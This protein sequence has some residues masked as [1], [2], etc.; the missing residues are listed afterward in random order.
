MEEPWSIH[1]PT[2]WGLRARVDWEDALTVKTM[3]FSP[4]LDLWHT[5]T[6]LDSYTEDGGSYPAHFDSRE[7]SI[8]DLRA[9]VNFALP[10]STSGFDIIANFEA[11]HRFDDESDST[12]GEVAGL[13]SFNLDGE[14]YDQDWLKGGIGVEG[15]LAMGKMSLMV[16]GS[17]DGEMPS[18]WIAA[19]Y[20]MSF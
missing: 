7:D 4:Y 1:K 2:S 12:S 9:G 8:T 17:T 13:F 16:N 3:R 10:I 14:N 20:Q 11:I 6:K 19:S 15:S 5:K 18:S